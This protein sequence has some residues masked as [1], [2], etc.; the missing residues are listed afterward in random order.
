MKLN[1]VPIQTTAKNTFVH[2]IHMKKLKYI[3]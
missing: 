2:V 3:H 1:I